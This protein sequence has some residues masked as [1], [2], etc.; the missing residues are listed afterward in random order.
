MKIVLYPDSRLIY[1]NKPLRQYGKEEASKIAEMLQLMYKTD[2]IGLAAPQVGWNVTLFVANLTGDEAGERIY[3]NPRIETS[4]DLVMGKE[5]CLSFPGILANILRRENVMITA[6]TPKG[7]IA[8]DHSEMAARVI[9][10]EFDHLDS[11]LFIERMNP[12][13]YRKHMRQLKNLKYRH[14]GMTKL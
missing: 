11:M 8:E 9:Q 13:E 3:I 4:G 10:H 6:D 5:G 14:T 12:A 7:P 1:P 2:G